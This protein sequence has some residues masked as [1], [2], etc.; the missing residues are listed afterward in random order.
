MAKQKAFIRIILLGDMAQRKQSTHSLKVDTA[1]LVLI[2][3]S[4]MRPRLNSAPLHT[5]GD[6]RGNVHSF[7]DIQDKAVEG[8]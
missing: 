1:A 8:S 7:K 4:S 2:C 3:G 6:L 5:P